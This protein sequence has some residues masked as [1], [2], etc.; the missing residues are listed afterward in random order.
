MHELSIG[1]LSIGSAQLPHAIKSVEIQQP[2]VEHFL[3]ENV[4]PL[5]AA[6][7]RLISRATTRYVIVL[8]E[9]MEL[10]VDACAYMLERMRTLSEEDDRLTQLM[11]RLQDPL[12][13]SLLGVRLLHVERLRGVPMRSTLCP[14]RDLTDRLIEAG[15]TTGVDAQ[16]TVGT[17]AR[18]RSDYELF[19]KN[20]VTASKAYGNGIEQARR[21]DVDRLLKLLHCTQDLPPEKAFALM[22]GIYWGLFH[23]ISTNASE[24]PADMWE[25]LLAAGKSLGY[26]EAGQRIASATAAIDERIAQLANAAPEPGYYRKA[27]YFS[28]TYQRTLTRICISDSDRWDCL[29]LGQAELAVAMNDTGVLNRVLV[30]EVSLQRLRNVVTQALADDLRLTPLEGVIECASADWKSAALDR[31]DTSDD[32]QTACSPGASGLLL[33]SPVKLSQRTVR[34]LVERYDT[35]AIHRRPLAASGIDPDTLVG[36]MLADQRWVVDHH[37]DKSAFLSRRSSSAG[38][39]V[40]TGTDPAASAAFQ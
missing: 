9:D 25:K 29:G 38:R 18:N 32:R 37:D 6:F 7:N 15:W 20:A 21:T 35:V 10:D 26:M 36:G 16:R 3:V 39:D 19:I 1:I 34:N 14:D 4:V 30:E 22:G 12:L 2:S 17:H 11:F 27:R 8:D 33:A 31:Q 40:S 28:A 13:G 24:Y 5:S 23:P